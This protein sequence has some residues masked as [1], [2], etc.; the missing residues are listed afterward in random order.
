MKTQGSIRWRPRPIVCAQHRRR[1][2]VRVRSF[3]GEVFTFHCVRPEKNRSRSAGEARPRTAGF[4]ARGGAHREALPQIRDLVGRDQ[5]GRSRRKI[6]DGRHGLVRRPASRRRLQTRERDKCNC[7]GGW[8]HL[9]IVVEGGPKEI[10]SLLPY[11]ESEH[12]Q[13]PHYNDMARLHSQRQPQRFWF[14]PEEILA[15]TESGWGDRNRMKKLSVTA[16]SKS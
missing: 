16:S 14:M 9:L 10:W 2:P 6:P 3:R 1:T 7:N 8:G 5:R 13:S 15:H 11:G 12:A 4:R